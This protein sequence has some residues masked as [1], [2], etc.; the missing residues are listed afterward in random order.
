MEYYTN[1]ILKYILVFI[2]LFIIIE[3][4]KVEVV[5]KIIEKCYIK[6]RYLNTIYI[7]CLFIL[8]FA[9]DKKDYKYFIGSFLVFQII[10]LV[11]HFYANNFKWKEVFKIIL[12]IIF[13][14]LGLEFMKDT[15][16][17]GVV[18]VGDIVSLYGI[19]TLY[20]LLEHLFKIVKLLF[21]RKNKGCI[22][23]DDYKLV[24]DKL[25][26][27][28]GDI[29]SFISSFNIKL[30]SPPKNI[31]IRY[32]TFRI[33]EIVK[34]IILFIIILISSFCWTAICLYKDGKYIS[35]SKV[36]WSASSMFI[37]M[38]SCIIILVFF[39]EWNKHLQCYNTYKLIDIHEHFK[40]IE[41]KTG[42][43]LVKSFGVVLVIILIL[44]LILIPLSILIVL[45]SQIVEKIFLF[46]LLLLLITYLEI[47]RR[48]EKVVE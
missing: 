33:R 25:E 3:G 14:S 42:N 30:T 9:I 17:E 15:S 27:E 23:T 36:E 47:L 22:F 7:L 43:L 28:L 6:L 19:V 16:L 20:Y 32:Y 45:D 12:F 31:T 41:D 37:A 26:V 5:K 46:L 34:S 21:I 35:I 44:I 39:E 11:I 2:V 24:D 4:S 10:F 18:G 8:N 1:I 38:F 13:V 48:M 40:K 29:K